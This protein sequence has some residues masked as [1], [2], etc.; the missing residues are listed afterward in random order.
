MGDA[1]GWALRFGHARLAAC[2]AARVA[3]ASAVGDQTAASEAMA[4]Y[5][6]ETNQVQEITPT[7]TTVTRF[8]ASLR[9]DISPQRKEARPLSHALTSD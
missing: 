7:L 6:R 1:A 5:Q 9:T 2:L 3:A 4:R 8:A